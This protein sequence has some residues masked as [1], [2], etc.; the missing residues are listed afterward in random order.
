M[1]YGAFVILVKPHTI[2]LHLQERVS[3]LGVGTSHLESQ[4]SKT[5]T[6]PR[7]KFVAVFEE[8]IAAVCVKVL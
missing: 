4:R 3:H 1:P 8:K 5:G 6:K 2:F 7:L